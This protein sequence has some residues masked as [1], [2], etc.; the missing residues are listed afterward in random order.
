MLDWKVA[1][2]CAL[3]P[4]CGVE[5]GSLL[6]WSF[7]DH[8]LCPVNL[9][10]NFVVVFTKLRLCRLCNDRDCVFGSAMT[11]SHSILKK[12]WFLSPKPILCPCSD[13]VL[14]PPSTCKQN[15]RMSLGT[16][17]TLE[18]QELHGGLWSFWCDTHLL[19]VTSKF[20]GL[21]RHRNFVG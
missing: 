15:G 17:K 11:R 5:R 16:K 20:L 18:G 21:L 13:C 8:G 6:G 2:D 12:T 10:H 14:L 4:K 7:S 9:G 19:G 3:L 1:I